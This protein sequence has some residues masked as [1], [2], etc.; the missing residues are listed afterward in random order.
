[1]PSAS[2]II[3]PL[4]QLDSAPNARNPVARQSSSVGDRYRGQSPDAVAEEFESLFV[5]MLLKNM[6]TSM[7]EEGLFGSDSSDTYGG[8]F[9]LFMSRHLAQGSP[10]GV[11]EMVKSYLD[12]SNAIPETLSGQLESTAEK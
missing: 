2:D 8:I 1:M 6:R 3:S 9:D 12:N 11:G 7:S 5:S 4:T 10:L